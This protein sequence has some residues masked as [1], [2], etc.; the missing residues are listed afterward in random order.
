MSDLRI[1]S[2]LT[3][4][5]VAATLA[6]VRAATDEDGVSPLSEHVMLHLRYGGDP[7]ARSFLLSRDR[8]L[9]GYAHLDPTDPVQGPSGELVVHPAFRR[10][11]LGLELLKA[12][13]AQAGEGADRPLRLWAHG[14]LPASARL[15]R[16]AGF[17]R[18]RAL[19]QM[20]RSLQSR[21]G[22]PRLADGLTVRTFVPG[23]DEDSWTALNGRAF[24]GHPEQGTW[25]RADL[26]LREREPWFDPDGFFLAERDGKLA[27]F[28][29][30]KIHDGTG[31]DGAGQDS[32]GR[33]HEP[34]GEV[35]VVGVDPGE[36]GSGL[37]RALTL[38]GLRYLRSRGLFQVMLYVDETNMAAIGMYESL[39]FSH[40]GTDVMYAA[41]SRG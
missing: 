28:H 32:E 25:T 18:I 12:V 33:H 5:D 22:R 36:R 24:A 9:A 6:L 19:W 10:R 14:D 4:E 21:I 40:W 1:T 35:Y 31:H 8:E 2:H 29:W 27:G 23:Q 37:G 3:G 20:R 34:I 11:G 38:V 13:D 17:E 39:G 41:P 30:T 7:F 26:D 15:A 16:T